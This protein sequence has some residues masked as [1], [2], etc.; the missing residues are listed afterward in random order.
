[1]FM[2]VVV[3]ENHYNNLIIHLYQK[4]WFHIWTLKIKHKYHKLNILLK[5]VSWQ[6]NYEKKHL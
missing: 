2:F 1:M 3:L 5:I 6:W 4:A